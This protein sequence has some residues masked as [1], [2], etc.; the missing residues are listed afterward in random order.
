MRVDREDALGFKAR[1]LKTTPSGGG[2]L[3][4]VFLS[5]FVII[6][7]NT[8]LLIRF[9]EILSFLLTF[10]EICDRIPTETVVLSQMGMC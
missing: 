7:M 10:Y 4:C 2:S 6:E 5:E 8:M 3:F 1:L 9:S